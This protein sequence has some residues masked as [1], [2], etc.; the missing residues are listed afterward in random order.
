M[1]RSMWLL[2]LLHLFCPTALCLILSLQHAKRSPDTDFFQGAVLKASF[3]EVVCHFPALA[4]KW[5][6]S[7][8]ISV[9]GRTKGNSLC[10]SLER[11]DFE[12]APGE[13]MICRDLRSYKAT[14][15]TEN[16]VS[17]CFKK[18]NLSFPHGMFAHLVL[19]QHL[20]NI[21]FV[22]SII[23]GTIAGCK[24]KRRFY[25][26]PGVQLSSLEDSTL[27][28]KHI[29]MVIQALGSKEEDI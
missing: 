2:F 24:K 29:R 13:K 5:S 22:E 15:S 14:C 11:M 7:N 20:W 3:P 21:Y 6:R 19:L 18:L 17:P 9:E 28:G 16:P 25:W 1:L 27:T 26:F 4:G 23:L 10:F 8:Y 12:Y